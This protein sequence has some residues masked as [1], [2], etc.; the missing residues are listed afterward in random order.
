MKIIK[1]VT[2][3]VCDDL[4]ASLNRHS[5]VSVAA[6]CFSIYAFEELL[7]WAFWFIHRSRENG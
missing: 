7:R 5:K 4:A 6:A 1:N 2:E 3:T